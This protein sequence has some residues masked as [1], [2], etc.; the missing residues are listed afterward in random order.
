MYNK[1]NFDFV[2]QVIARIYEKSLG[3]ERFKI[4][5]TIKGLIINV[6]FCK[7]KLAAILDYNS[8]FTKVLYMFQKY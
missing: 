6:G 3:T 4:G 7:K 5:C 1:S 8:G 2:L